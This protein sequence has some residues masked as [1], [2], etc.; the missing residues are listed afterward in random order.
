MFIHLAIHRPRPEA[1]ALVIESMH[2][3]G[4]AMAGQPGFVQV[5]TLKEPRKGELVGLAI[6]ESKEAWMAAR[7]AMQDA[8]K[9]DPFHEWEDTPPD[10]YHLE[11]V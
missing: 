6:W 10:V 5:H 2:R 1:E 3:F 9:D 7:P 8:V 4:A 11:D